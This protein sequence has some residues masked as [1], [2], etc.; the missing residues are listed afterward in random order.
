MANLAWTKESDHSLVDCFYCGWPLPDV[1]RINYF[2]TDENYK[3]IS[4]LN[5]SN[6]HDFLYYIV[7][8]LSTVG[9]GEIFP[10][11]EIGRFVILLFIVISSYSIP[12]QIN[13]LISGK[14]S[15]PISEEIKKNQSK[16]SLLLKEEYDKCIRNLNEQILESKNKISLL[17][18][19]NID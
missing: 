17:T 18:F 12:K 11:T 7:V 14:K 10:I 1:D 8:T 3:V 16:L 5:K 4:L 6:F 19:F 9:Y 2:I 13:E 15:T